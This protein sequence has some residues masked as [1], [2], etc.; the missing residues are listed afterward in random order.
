L[1]PGG[2]AQSTLPRAIR[3]AAHLGEGDA[4][5]SDE[6]SCHEPTLRFRSSSPS[7]GEEAQGS[8]HFG[9][10]PPRTRMLD[11]GG[12][13]RQHGDTQA[14][15]AQALWAS[16]KR[17]RPLSARRDEDGG[18]LHAMHWVHPKKRRYYQAFVLQDLLG[19][20]E[21][22]AAWGALDSQ[23]GG[24]LRKVVGSREAG[25]QVIAQLG[26]RRRQR[27]YVARTAAAPVNP[28]HDPAPHG[29]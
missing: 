4:L 22:V 24:S 28:H 19:D 18:M 13:V 27:G 21:V 2:A 10:E 14:R 16:S 12:A 26:Q 25:A 15:A 29:D 6:R 20:W 17:A 23:Q 11:A 1:V 8:V 7:Y 5:G 3:A 9:F